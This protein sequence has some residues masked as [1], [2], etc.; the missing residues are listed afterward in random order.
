MN[1][2]SLAL[3]LPQ[4]PE[5]ARTCAHLNLPMR[6]CKS[7]SRSGM[8][9]SWQVQSR[10]LRLLGRVDL[11]SRGPVAE[12][13]DQVSDWLH[14][15]QRWHDR[16]PLILNADG[17]SP[18]EL[19]E[20]GFWPLLTPSTIGLLPLGD[21]TQMR[22]SLKQKWRNRLNKAEQNELKT[23]RYALRGQNWLLDV[24][25]VQARQKGYRGL[26]PTFW[27]SFAQANPGQAVVFEAQ[28]NG[29]PVASVLILLHGRMATWQIGYS[30]DEGRQSCAMNLL[31]W[32]TMCWLA[33]RGHDCLDLGVLNSDD[34]KGLA[35]FKL[36]TGAR[37]HQLGGTWLHY[38]P[39]A[40]L[41][42]RLPRGLLH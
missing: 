7:E 30:N 33:S 3:P 18:Q 2:L 32:Q 27:A 40:P 15:W 4:S 5:F 20:A 39:L 1:G 17:I 19:R 36:G 10:K 26:P 13:P 41:A 28:R 42:R 25:Q 8:R 16:R 38:G 37:A 24:E 12:D 6:R 23:H 21:T 31:I 29:R 22:A 35:H 14:R 11:V 9:L 34:A